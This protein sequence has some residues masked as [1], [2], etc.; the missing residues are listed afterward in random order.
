MERD[1]YHF[2]HLM[3]FF[4]D[5]KKSA[6]EAHQEISK[7]YGESAPALRTCQY[8]FQRFKAG[9]FSVEDEERSG[10][11]ENFEDKELQA[12][13][14]EDPTQSENQLA[15]ALGVDRSTV[16]RRLKKMG[17][18][19]KESKWVPYKLSESAIENRF[20]ICNSLLS[21]N[22]RKAF[23]NKIVTGDE[24][25]IYYDN[26]KRKKAWVDPG[27]PTPMIP[28]RNIHGKKA[29]KKALLC[30]WWDSKG[31]VY[32]ELFKP[33]QTFTADSYQ[34]QMLKVNQ[35]LDKKRPLSSTKSR[36][37]ILLH[38]NAP[39][40]KSKKVQGT[41]AELKWEVLLHPA[42][43][44]DIAPSDYHLF[45]SMRSGLLEQEFKE[46]E[47]VE[48]WVTDWIASKPPEF[49]NDGIHSLPKRWQKVV[50]SEGKYFC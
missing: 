3:L 28:K 10:R 43:S 29:K 23:L 5:T 26:P 17:K 18:I 40:D 48:N 4:F 22:R 6:V 33:G 21:R 11:P 7:I 39:L 16:S 38:D 50:T 13:L 19:L 15:Q 37:V 24:K 12:L 31:V 2:R 45:R 14:D 42:Y 1:K 44:P 41:I 46:F 49:F 34:Q 20:N 27:Q 32:F 36:Q 35:A 8:W 30:I 47:E 9:N 25:W